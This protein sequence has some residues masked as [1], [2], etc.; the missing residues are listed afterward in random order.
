MRRVALASLLALLA[1][2]CGVPARALSS[3]SEYDAFRE[4]RVAYTAEDRLVAAERYLAR[5]PAG[6]FADE[7]RQRF[8][9]EERAFFDAKSVSVTGLEWYLTVLPRGPHAS[10]ASLRLAD[11]S[12]RTQ[13]Q[14]KDA[15]VAKARTIEARLAA[16]AASRQAAADTLALWVG[17]VAT[18]TTW[19]EPTWR[20]SGDALLA[21]RG[22]PEPGRCGETRCTRTRSLTFQVPV[23]GGG[24]EE[25][26]A[27]IDYV[28]ELRDGGVD[29]IQ[30]R[31]PELFSRMFEASRGVPLDADHE[32]ARAEAVSYALEVVSGAFER[33]APGATCERPITPPVVLSR[34][35]DGWSIDVTI[36]DTAADDDVI[37]VRRK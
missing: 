33:V 18:V 14:R 11:L 2:G 3:P 4:T 26:A 16:A 24:L 28:V 8:A 23:A 9:S 7:V 15:L 27:T 37:A 20:L 32:R 21:L 1:A 10:D 17:S 19:G 5:Y 6:R 29:R 22:W 35:C 13:T 25:R 34:R 31:G 36:G 12:S 30:I